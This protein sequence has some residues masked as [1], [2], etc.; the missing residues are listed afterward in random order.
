MIDI[1]ESVSL[2]S[3]LDGIDHAT[4]KGDWGVIVVKA[5]TYQHVYWL[6]YNTGSIPSYDRT[7]NNYLLNKKWKSSSKDLEDSKYKQNPL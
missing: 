4:L 1:Y 6:L 7:C 5:L 2:Q 3:F